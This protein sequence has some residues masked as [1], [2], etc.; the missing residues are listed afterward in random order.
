MVKLDKIVSNEIEKRYKE[1]YKETEYK[2]NSI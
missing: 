2:T 1:S